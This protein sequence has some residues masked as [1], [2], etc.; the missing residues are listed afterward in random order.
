[1]LEP[2]A[3]QLRVLLSAPATSLEYFKAQKIEKLDYDL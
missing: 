2:S 3:Q 1:L